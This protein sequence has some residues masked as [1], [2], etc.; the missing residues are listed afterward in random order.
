MIVA[1]HQPNYLPWLGFFDKIKKSDCFIFMDNVQY[2][3]RSWM[4]RVK[5]KTKGGEKLLTVPLQVRGNYH[6]IIKN[7][8]IFDEEPWRKKHLLTIE[9]NYSKAKYYTKFF[10][11][12]EKII[13]GKQERICEL[14]ISLT[15]LVCE[16]IKLKP[17]FILGSALNAEGSGTDLLIN[18]VKAVGGD[19]YLCGGGASGYQD[20]EKFSSAGIKLIYQD[21]KHPEYP[22]LY[23]EFIAGLSCIDWIFNTG[24]KE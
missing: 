20:D 13:T 1:I 9:H 21:F 23:G 12:I 11:E 24:A 22:Q 19:T 4:N 8:R 2:P 16:I 6:E 17:S 18:M 15:K 14:N 5:I 10:P 7:M 3:R